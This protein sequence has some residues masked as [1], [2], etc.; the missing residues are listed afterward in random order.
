MGFN[1][2]SVEGPVG[3]PPA[4]V[5]GY[6]AD[7]PDHHRHFLPPAF[8]DFEVASGG[9]GAGTVTT[10]RFSAGGQTRDFRTTGTS[11]TT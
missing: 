5:F 2:V 9:V 10:F 7:M 8:S 4:D 11:T 3:A 6:I 1:S